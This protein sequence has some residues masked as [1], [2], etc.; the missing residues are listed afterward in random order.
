MASQYIFLILI[1]HNI[2]Y[3]FSSSEINT[4]KVDI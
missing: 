1:E 4:S 3:L 2:Y